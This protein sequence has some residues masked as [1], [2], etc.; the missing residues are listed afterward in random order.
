MGARAWLIPR[1][2][3]SQPQLHVVLG[4]DPGQGQ[5]SPSVR[6]PHVGA[7]A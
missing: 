4:S 1:A 2:R 6:H 7:R 3:A 5:V